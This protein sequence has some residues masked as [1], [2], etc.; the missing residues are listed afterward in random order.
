VLE[1]IGDLLSWS[2]QQS[3][4]AERVNAAQANAEAVAKSYEI[5]EAARSRE[6][7]NAF[8]EDTAVDAVA[9]AGSDAPAFR[10]LPR[11][12]AQ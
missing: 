1:G 4:L 9:G 5:N 10:A 7:Y 12:M 6:T 3:L 8:L 2:A 11:W